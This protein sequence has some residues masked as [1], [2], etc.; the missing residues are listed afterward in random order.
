MPLMPFV[1]PDEIP[2]RFAP[3]RR[4]RLPEDIGPAERIA[5]NSLSPQMRRVIGWLSMGGVWS[6]AQLGVPLRT[7]Q[8]WA[9]MGVIQR[10]PFSTGQVAE[11]LTRYGYPLDGRKRSQIT[12]YRLG[13]VGEVLAKHLYPMTPLHTPDYSLERLMHDFFTNEIV[14]RLAIL[15]REQGWGV[16]WAGTNAAELRKGSEQILEPDALLV[17]R[18]DDGERVYAVEYH[19]ERGTRRA[20]DKVRR[21]ERAYSMDDLWE[22]IW[23]TETFP[24]VLAVFHDPAVGRGYKESLTQKRSNVRFYGKLLRSLFEGKVGTWKRI[25]TGT[26]E[27]LLLLSEEELSQEEVQHA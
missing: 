13:S 10:L 12:L 5:A 15:G 17:F 2:S 6:A 20:R 18:R 19:G 3:G 21:Y 7:L 9:Q 8:R 24:A 4:P 1:L 26:R 14:L 11:T 25:D 27:N 16:W 22:S 23:E